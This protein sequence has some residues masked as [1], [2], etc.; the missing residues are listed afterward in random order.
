MQFLN[1][2]KYN[3]V[4]LKWIYPKNGVVAKVPGCD[5]VVNEFELQSRYIIHFRTNT[6]GKGINHLISRAMNIIS[7]LFFD[8]DSFGI[9]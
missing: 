1:H 2:K 6:I 9:K 7:L 4:T 5:I 3:I 8:R